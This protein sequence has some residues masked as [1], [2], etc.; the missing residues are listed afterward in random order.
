MGN[1]ANSSIGIVRDS[2]NSALW[3][4]THTSMSANSLGRL[5]YHLD[6]CN[7]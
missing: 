1:V 6:G 4:H 5:A 7:R 3:S 2:P